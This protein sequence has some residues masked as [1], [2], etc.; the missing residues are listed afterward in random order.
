MLGWKCK[1]TF[2]WNVLNGILKL[3]SHK[4]NRRWTW[5]TKFIF[6]LLNQ[7]GRALEL[8][9]RHLKQWRPLLETTLF[10]CFYFYWTCSVNSGSSVLTFFNRKANRVATW[11]HILFRSWKQSRLMTLLSNLA[12]S[13][14]N[15]FIYKQSGTRKLTILCV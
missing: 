7:Q 15:I 10:N 13:V 2:M 12:D 9:L 14:K 11:E 4:F 5:F 3:K 1:P 8:Y 6:N